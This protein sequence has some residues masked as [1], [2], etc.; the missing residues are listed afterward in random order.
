MSITIRSMIDSPPRQQAAPQP[1]NHRPQTASRLILRW[2]RLRL[3]FQPDLI[4]DVRPPVG[5]RRG[6]KH[7]LSFGSVS[8]KGACDHGPFVGAQ[9]RTQSWHDLLQAEQPNHF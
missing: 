5:G 2:K 1:R 3:A 4:E 6:K 8:G 9:L 7:R